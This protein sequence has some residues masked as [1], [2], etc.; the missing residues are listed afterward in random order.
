MFPEIVSAQDDVMRTFDDEEEA[1]SNTLD[2]GMKLFEGM[3]TKSESGNRVLD[4]LG[5]WRLYDTF[6]FPVDLTRI[7]A[8]ERNLTIDEQGFEAAKASAL[9]ASKRRAAK[10][11]V[12]VIK[13]DVHDIGKLESMSD[14]PKTDDSFKY[15]MHMLHLGQIQ[16][17]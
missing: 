13:L 3:A 10:S 14:V 16:F 8:E 17:S 12:E 6:G 15:G 5:V 11:G 1:F 9:E 4:G 7:I 2:R